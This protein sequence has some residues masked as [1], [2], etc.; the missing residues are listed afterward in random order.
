ML[1][2]EISKIEPENKLHLKSG[3][4]LTDRKDIE[5]WIESAASNT[6][7][8]IFFN[9][10]NTVNIRGS[11]SLSAEA[12]DHIPV[13]F[14]SIYGTFNCEFNYLKSFENLPT[15]VAEQ[16][17]LHGNNLS[18]FSSLREPITCDSITLNSNHFTS[19]H[20]IHKH[21]KHIGSSFSFSGGV[22]N[23]LG[24]LMIK[25]LSEGLII[26]PSGI[27]NETKCH[28]LQDLMDYYIVNKRGDVHQCQ[29][30][31]LDAGFVKEAR[32]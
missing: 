5:D 26:H 25:N 19:F 30:E 1:L 14:K 11:I 31:L 29:E 4:T 20:N 6:D 24:L 3:T 17:W 9:S 8:D 13:K 16:Y 15:L 27:Y 22:T 32:F 2:T 12:L 7:F 10:D 23:L 28:Q 21:F 18:S